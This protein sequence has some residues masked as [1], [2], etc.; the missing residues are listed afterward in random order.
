MTKRNVLLALGL[1]VAI[2]GVTIAS[3]AFSQVE[4]DRNISIDVENDDSAFVNITPAESDFVSMSSDGQVEIDT[5]GLGSGVHQ[6]ATIE[7]KKALTF[8]HNGNDA[9]A[10]NVTLKTDGID[11]AN[12]DIS[13]YDSNDN[14]IDES[15][16]FVLQNTSDSEDVYFKINTTDG[17]DNIDGTFTIVIEEE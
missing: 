7:T 3:G 15:N 10:Y 2:A 12:G 9:E 13:M 14:K 4:A 6:N 11:S 16:G 17:A 5:D 8:A 1:I